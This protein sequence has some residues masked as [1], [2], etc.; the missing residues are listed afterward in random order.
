MGSLI[1]LKGQ[2]FGRLVVI[3]RVKPK[4]PTRW[5]C[6]CDCGK[7]SKVV[8]HS[9]MSGRTTS[10]GCFAS[11]VLI[12]RNRKHGLYFTREHRMWRAAKVRAE[13]SNLEFDIQVADI[14]IPEKCPILGIP[15]ILDSKKPI[16]ASP[17][18]DRVDNKQGYVKNNIVV[19]STRANRIKSDA[20]VD[21]L[22]AIA[23]FLEK[24]R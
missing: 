20:T 15:L 16:D 1:N 23:N 4:H 6:L 24:R 19:I 17:A 11:D 7:T 21:E 9:L 2:K 22:F 3:K 10:C 12:K 5:L 13:K 14:I 8:A 18:L